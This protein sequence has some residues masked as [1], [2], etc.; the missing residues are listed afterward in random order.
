[1]SERVMKTKSAESDAERSLLDSA[2]TEM[3][4]AGLGSGS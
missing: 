3:R 2:G 1:M 4:I